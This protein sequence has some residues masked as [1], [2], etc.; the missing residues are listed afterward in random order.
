M[1]E[2][3]YS[4]LLSQLVTNSLLD[5]VPILGTNDYS[6][7]DHLTEKAKKYLQLSGGRLT[8]QELQLYLNVDRHH[9]DKVIQKVGNIY[10]L[11]KCMLCVMND[12]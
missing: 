2:Q 8:S 12:D 3:T 4:D 7:L 9:V 5:V 6:T 1:N 10:I 11:F